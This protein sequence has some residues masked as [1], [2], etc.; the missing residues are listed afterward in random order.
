MDRKY[1]TD[2]RILKRFW[3]LSI[4]TILMGICFMPG[5]PLVMWLTI[6]YIILFTIV[7]AFSIFHPVI[8]GNTLIIKNSLF[9]FTLTKYRLEKIEKLKLYFGAYAYL[10]IKNKV[11][12]QEN[13]KIHSDSMYGSQINQTIRRGTA[14]KRSASRV[15]TAEQHEISFPNQFNISNSK[16][17]T[18]FFIYIKDNLRGGHHFGITHFLNCS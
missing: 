1:F 15:R 9:R 8:D 2:K 17:T 18:A 3:G 5:R 14:F 4:P 10:C 16:Q 11:E 12:K 13:K 6:G 7:G